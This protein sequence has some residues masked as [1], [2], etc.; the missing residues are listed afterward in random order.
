M[1]P[2]K[3]RQQQPSVRAS[4]SNP[5]RGKGGV[6]GDRGSTQQQVVRELQLEMMGRVICPDVC[7]N[8]P[9][10]MNEFDGSYMVP[11]SEDVQERMPQD[12]KQRQ[13]TGYQ[14]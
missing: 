2:A 10:H 7:P 9:K 5:T 3:G 12:T 11:Y 14:N 8:T 4:R 6:G 1:D 13:R